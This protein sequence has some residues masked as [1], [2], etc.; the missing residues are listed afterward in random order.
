LR[1]IAQCTADSDSCVTL[2][3]SASAGSITRIRP[4]AK[5]NRREFLRVAGSTLARTAIPPSLRNSLGL[6]AASV[7]SPAGA[8][9][10]EPGAAPGHP[11]SPKKIRGVMVDAAR[12][13]ETLDYYHRVIAFCAEWQLN[14]IHFR[15]ADDQGTALRFASVPGLFSHD[16]AFTPDQFHEL[17]RFASSCGVDLIPEIESFGHT[18]F[19]TRSATYAH[20][21]DAT[22]DS[23]SDFTGVIPVHPETL[24]LFAKLYAEIAEIFPS[25]YLHGGCDEVNWGGSALSQQ[26]LQSKSRSQIWA[27]YLNSLSGLA[28]GLGKQ[29]IV[30]GDFVLHKEP[31]I[32]TGLNK[33]IIVMDWNYW[34]TSADK[35]HDALEK[36]KAHGA[37]AIG[38][39]GLISYRWGARAG[40]DQL[41]N[42]DAF[43]Q[44]YLE[45]N[46]PGS[47]G[48]ILT[49]WIPSRYVQ[50]SIWDGIAYAAVAFNEGTAAA[51]KSAFRHFIEMHYRAEWNEDWSKAFQ[52][53]YDAAPGF[54]EHAPSAGL[55]LHMPVPWSTEADL[56]AALKKRSPGSN[57]FTGLHGL[58]LSLGPS[59]H[60][61]H[62]DF[63]AFALSV[64]YLEGVFW[65]ESVIRDQVG[66]GPIERA[67]A[68]ALIR[69]IAERDHKLAAALSKDWDDGRFPDSSA[70]TKP[71]FA[72][73]PKDQLVF[74]FTRAAAYSAS[75]S[76]RSDHFF[77]LLESS[78][79]GS[80]ASIAEPNG[81]A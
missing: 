48:V 43:A 79:L 22:A 65:R 80:I 24:Q 63:Q 52:L 81:C 14:T 19:I 1:I 72:N 34:D 38:A 66:K 6:A 57:P 73:Q 69:E 62:S 18:G 12:V 26:A 16:H 71:L 4:M 49:N 76:V 54:G 36:V 74:Q 8:S 9:Q 23:S 60:A 10:M 50:S 70:K 17:I 61:N 59:V 46:D 7:S 21:L 27:E 42:I 78:G 25:P 53:I 15:L 33:N 55:G 5:H 45:T 56:Q 44:A 31:E 37:R 40:T 47:L 13:P 32:L 39:P 2:A 3:T 30:W 11:P 64:E 29:F 68:A 77:Q 20:L 67:G 28:E 35:F 51:Q 58:L 75:L 41:R